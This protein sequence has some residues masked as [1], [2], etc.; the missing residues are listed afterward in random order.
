MKIKDIIF[1]APLPQPAPSEVDQYKKLYGKY[2]NLG[3][4]GLDDLDD[5]KQLG[6]GIEAKVVH[7]PREPEVTKIVGSR[8][9]IKQNAY[10]QYILLSRKYANEN[11]Y[12]PRVESI[13]KLGG[14][15]N[16][17]YD[18]KPDDAEGPVKEYYVIKLEKLTPLFKASAGELEFIFNT[19][20]Y[21]GKELDPPMPA[22][23]FGDENDT[24]NHFFRA[25]EDFL[26][27]SI[28]GENI[29][30][31]DPRLKAVINLIRKLIK[32]GAD[33]DLHSGN[34]MVRRTPHGAQLVI[35]D[36][37]HTF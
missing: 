36:P 4:M 28:E 29:S 25:I 7:D 33:N 13:Q 22:P 18:A 10:M 19:M 1:E 2:S 20:F 32:G 12:L 16:P 11:P 26:V 30:R 24:K 31:T 6:S 37:L 23:R 21:Y 34:M 15:D 5:Y 3:D 8:Q 17:Y 27:Q 9:A 35:T 14:G